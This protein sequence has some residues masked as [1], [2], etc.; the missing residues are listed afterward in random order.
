MDEVRS[1]EVET[2]DL[3]EMGVDS[4]LQPSSSRRAAYS[5]SMVPGGLLVMS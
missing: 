5:H 4:L 2:L 3:S 1:D